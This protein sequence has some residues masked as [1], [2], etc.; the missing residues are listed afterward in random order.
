MNSSNVQ[1]GLVINKFVLRAQITGGS[2][3]EAAWV[4]YKKVRLGLR[5]QVRYSKSFAM[6]LSKQ[7]F[8]LAWV[9]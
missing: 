4:L 6:Q 3:Q 5:R 7:C 2:E 1:K 8:I 9:T